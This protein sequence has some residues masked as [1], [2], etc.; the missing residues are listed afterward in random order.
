MKDWKDY[1][2]SRGTVK[3]G[4]STVEPNVSE[5]FQIKLADNWIA[6]T[7]IFVTLVFAVIGVCCSFSD[8]PPVS[9]AAKW[10]FDAAKLCL[11]VFLGSLTNQKAK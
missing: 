3:A 8:K 6:V 4:S 2:Q 5:Y 11:G 7:I 1:A 9:D 10:F